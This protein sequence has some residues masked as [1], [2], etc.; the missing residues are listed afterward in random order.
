MA[1][2][3][4]SPGGLRGHCAAGCSIGGPSGADGV[5]ENKVRL[6]CPYRI[7]EGAEIFP[8]IKIR[9]PVPQTH[10]LNPIWMS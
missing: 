1:H 10:H 6:Y 4:E 7:L 8:V 5:R 3:I 2:Y 9:K